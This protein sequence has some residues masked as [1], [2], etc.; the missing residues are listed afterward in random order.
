MEPVSFLPFPYEL[1][2]RLVAASVFGA[3][4]GLERDIHG[5]AAGLRT[6]LLVCLGSALFMIISIYTGTLNKDAYFYS[7]LRV[8]PGRIAA[9]IITGIGFLGAGTIIKEGFSIRGLTTAACMWIVAGIGMAIGAGYYIAAGAT[10]GIGLFT[11]IFLNAIEKYYA[12]DSYRIME[13]T[14]G[15]KSD[16]G[17]ITDLLKSK[18]I[19][20][21]HCDF[22]QDFENKKMIIKYHL[23]THYKGAA[24]KVSS[25]LLTELHEA[26]ILIKS[27]KWYHI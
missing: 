21:L 7:V 22:D 25:K 12:K 19:K 14:T 4:I 20:I 8:D 18:Y 17:K 26:D 9:Q 16:L 27:I 15:I 6:N 5:R 3:L 2:L 11:L 23:R 13:I 1:I 24:D 10:T